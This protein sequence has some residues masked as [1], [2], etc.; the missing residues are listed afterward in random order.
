MALNDDKGELHQ[1]DIPSQA[2]CNQ[3]KV[4][5]IVRAQKEDPHI[6]HVLKFM[7]ANQ[8]P[9]VGKKQKE[10]PLVCKLLNEWHK[11]HLN[12]KS[13]L[14][15]C[16]HQAVLPQKFPHTVYHE[17]HEEIG[18]FGVERVLALA[19]ERFYWPHMRETL[20]TLSIAHAAA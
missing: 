7:K 5:D 13:G 20:K 14:L 2:G 8:K 3:V 11:L 19:R 15:Y 17:L 12:R 18:L 6:G 10:L 4:V 9:T 1:V 16:N